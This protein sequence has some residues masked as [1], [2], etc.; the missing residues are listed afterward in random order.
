MD[1]RT[2]ELPPV[3]IPVASPIKMIYDS[4]D[5]SCTV[6]YLACQRRVY[7][8]RAEAGLTS[9]SPFPSTY[10]ESGIRYTNGICRIGLRERQ[11]WHQG[12]AGGRTL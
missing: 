7:P 1:G 3:P 9:Y 12:E 8:S 11:P 6:I 2:P 10:A 4:P 5:V